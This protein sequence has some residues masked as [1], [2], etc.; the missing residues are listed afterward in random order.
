MF[1]TSL[2]LV[3]FLTLNLLSVNASPFSPNAKIHARVV[4]LDWVADDDF[5]VDTVNSIHNFNLW[6][7]YVRINFTMEYWNTLAV[8][9]AVTDPYDINARPSAGL[10]VNTDSGVDTRVPRDLG[11]FG[12]GITQDDDPNDCRA[13]VETIYSRFRIGPGLTKIPN[14]TTFIRFNQSGVDDWVEGNYTFT[15]LQYSSIAF[16]LVK[17]STG[18]FTFSDPLPENWGE[19]LSL[20]YGVSLGILPLSSILLLYGTPVIVVVASLF[21]IKFYRNRKKM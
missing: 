6:Y 20:G 17:N 4:S 21:A 12:K 15:F 8:S 14:L 3:C 11:C 10:A 16:H 5:D 1:R 19:T 18:V 7:S 13:Y 9:V 2:I